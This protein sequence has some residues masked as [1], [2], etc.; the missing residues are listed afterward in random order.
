MPSY[1]GKLEVGLRQ[2]RA[3]EAGHY[4]RLIRA[5]HGRQ[6]NA[7]AIGEGIHH[8]EAHARCRFVHYIRALLCGPGCA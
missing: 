6:T 8:A 7:Q 3:H 1:R 4:F 2:G 5:L